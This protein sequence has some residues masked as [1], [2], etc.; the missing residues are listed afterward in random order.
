MAI[1]LDT[2]PRNA[3]WISSLWNWPP[4]KSDEFRE[5]LRF[6]ELTLAEFRELPVYQLAIENGLIVKDEWVPDALEALLG[7]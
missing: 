4:Y 5:E 7:P 3:H 1:K 2:E 6:R